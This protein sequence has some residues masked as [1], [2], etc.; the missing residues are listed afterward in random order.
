MSPAAWSDWTPQLR[1]ESAQILCGPVDG[2]QALLL[3]MNPPLSHVANR[4]VDS[5][6]G[7]GGI[8]AAA[9]EAVAD[10]GCASAEQRSR[11]QSAGKIAPVASGGSSR[12]E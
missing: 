4:A 9:A 7:L 5:N 12:G 3:M 6:F 10:D 2:F 1:Y 8:P 11:P